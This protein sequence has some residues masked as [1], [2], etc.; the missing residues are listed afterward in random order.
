LP[1][2][3]LQLGTLVDVPNQLFRYMAGP[4]IIGIMLVPLL[5]AGKRP[6]PPSA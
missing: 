1:A 5:F 3:S 4:I 2:S 6:A